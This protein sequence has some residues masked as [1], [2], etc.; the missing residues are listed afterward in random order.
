[1]KSNSSENQDCREVTNGD[2][3]GKSEM[4]NNFSHIGEKGFQGKCGKSDNMLCVQNLQK[5]EIYKQLKDK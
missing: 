5:A 2:K 3:E 4:M 1:M